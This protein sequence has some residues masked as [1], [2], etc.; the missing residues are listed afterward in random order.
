MRKNHFGIKCVPYKSK[1]HKGYRYKK[2][3]LA[4][5]CLQRKDDYEWDRFEMYQ[6]P[7]VSYDRHAKLLA[8]NERYNWMLNR[9]FTGEMYRV[10]AKWFG[11][12]E[13]PYYA[14]WAIG[15]KKSGYATNKHY[16]QKVALIIETY[17]L[18]RIDY[19]I[20]FN[21]HVKPDIDLATD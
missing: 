11:V 20:I 16:A 19:N 6:S 7:A 10:P 8:N 2:H 15:L 4:Y 13:V 14:A 12:E 18:W 3:S 1:K 9:Y 17:E 21:S 5:D